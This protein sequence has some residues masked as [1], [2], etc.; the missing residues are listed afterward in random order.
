MGM[1]SL[2]LQAC[3]CILCIFAI[4][5]AYCKYAPHQ[6]F[7]CADLWT[8]NTTVENEVCNQ[9]NEA[10]ISQSPGKNIGSD[11]IVC[12][13][14]APNNDPIL[15]FGPAHELF[16]CADLW[17]LNTTV[18][19]QVCKDANEADIAQSPGNNIGSDSIVCNKDS[20]GKPVNN[21]FGGLKMWTDAAFNSCLAGPSQLTPSEIKQYASNINQGKKIPGKP[22]ASKTSGGLK[23]TWTDDKFNSCLAGDSKLTS[24]EIKQ[25]SN[26]INKGKTIPGKPNASKGSKPAWCNTINSL[27]I[28]SSIPSWGP[29]F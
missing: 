29:I 8:L 7:Y 20:S 9:A 18:E 6:L 3:C 11:S 22:N 13:K 1:E 26:N 25:Y 4:I 15:A 28:I 24:N 5:V 17:T 27:P 12:D 19:N 21:I 23:K 10:A 16:Y 14:A 2:I